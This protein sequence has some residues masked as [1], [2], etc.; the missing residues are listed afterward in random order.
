[1]H[2]HFDLIIYIFKCK[3]FYTFVSKIYGECQMLLM[4][5]GFNTIKV[6][7]STHVK[8][9]IIQECGKTH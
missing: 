3:C 6:N 5:N 1:M 9:L 7:N 4:N 8:I 2:Q